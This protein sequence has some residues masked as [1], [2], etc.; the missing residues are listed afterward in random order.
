MAFNI[1]PPKKVP[2]DIVSV[3]DGQQVPVHFE[4]TDH[5]ISKIYDMIEEYGNCDLSEYARSIVRY[6]AV[7]YLSGTGKE[8]PIGR[9][10]FRRLTDKNCNITRC[11]KWLVDHGII[12]CIKRGSKSAHSKSVW[13]FAKPVQRM[14]DRT[15][16][17]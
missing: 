12:E 16:L 6:M 15:F 3:L 7:W 4:I 5:T 9:S 13:S 11:T 2:F 8:V 17:R 14:L 10:D 1:Q